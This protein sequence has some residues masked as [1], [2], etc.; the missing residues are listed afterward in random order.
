MCL[1]SAAITNREQAGQL[2]TKVGRP[3]QPLRTSAHVNP[4]R[5][6]VP[7]HMG[8]KRPYVNVWAGASSLLARYFF[9]VFRSRQ[10][11]AMIMGPC[12]LSSSI[13]TTSLSPIICAPFLLHQHG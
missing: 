4:C 10:A 11:M 1:L 7:E 13:K 3:C 5:W 9:T 2:P 8:G 12:L 6:H